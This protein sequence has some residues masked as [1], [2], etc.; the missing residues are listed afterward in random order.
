MTPWKHKENDVLTSV[1]W[2]QRGW[3]VN[4]YI[5]QCDKRIYI[6]TDQER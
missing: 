4:T 5:Q 3:Y 6:Y 1:V 2:N